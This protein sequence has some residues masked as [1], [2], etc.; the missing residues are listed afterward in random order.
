MTFLLDVNVL[1]AL[2]EPEHV[3]HEA[4]HLWFEAEGGR[5]WATCPLTENGF[6]R[7][8]GNPRYLNT[9]GGP[10]AAAENLRAMRDH[11]GHVFWPDSVSLFDPL[12]D[13]AKITAPGQVTDAYL[14]ALAVRREGFLATLDRRIDP[15]GVKGGAAALRMIA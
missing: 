14:L 3:F 2:S 11:P 10:S 13:L 8:V 4:A 15:A 6:V 1:I 5:A 12:V 9:P 7:I